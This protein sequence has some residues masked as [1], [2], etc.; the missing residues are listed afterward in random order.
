[1]PV[2]PEQRARL[3]NSDLADV[4]AQAR[5]RLAAQREAEEDRADERDGENPSYG[6]G[7]P[8]WE[9]DRANEERSG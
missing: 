7:N 9:H 8:D 6:P 3:F 5:I 4:E 1:M 2:S